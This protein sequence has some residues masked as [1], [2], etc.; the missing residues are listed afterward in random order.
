ML[1]NALLI[2]TN[3]ITL[4]L[5]MVVGLLLGKR[6]SL[7]EPTQNQLAKL[8]NTIITPCLI[9]TNM[10][11]KSDR[12]TWEI[13]A[14]TFVIMIV[15]LAAS[16]VLAQVLFRRQPRDLKITL[17]YSIIYGN[18][19]YLGV[20]LV[21]ATFGGEAMVYVAVGGAAFNLMV[22]THGIWLMGSGE[23]KLSSK[24]ILNPGTLCFLL[25]VLL[26]VLGQRLPEPADK[27]VS[28]LAGMNTP[29][30]MLIVGAQMASADIR[31]IFYDKT[32]YFNS[33]VRLIFVP[34]CVLVALLPL[35]LERMLYLTMVILSACPVATLSSTFSQLYHRDAKT[36]ARAVIQSTILS[37]LTLPALTVLAQILYEFIW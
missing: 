25:G 19:G 37:L 15:I 17:R 29:L 16:A 5:I 21:Q 14:R 34:V 4:L 35:H 12:E 6:G 9:L 33:F 24:A 13:L 22:W 2:V 20:P 36:G 3:V 11:E 30:A 27:A 31:S 8:L 23:E 1:S 7:S 26:M 32:L 28:L 18:I 10:P